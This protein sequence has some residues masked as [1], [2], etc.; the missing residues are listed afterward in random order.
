M[1]IADGL[2]ISYRAEVGVY[3][4]TVLHILHDI[5]GYR[6]LPARWIHHEISEVE[7]WHNY[8]IAQALSD[9]YQR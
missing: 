1:L 5:L 4:T 2:R 8:A 7:Q 3:H 6:K 9:R